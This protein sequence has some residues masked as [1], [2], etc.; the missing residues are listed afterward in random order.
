MSNA[1]ITARLDVITS[2]FLDKLKSELKITNKDVFMMGIRTIVQDKNIQKKFKDDFDEILNNNKYRKDTTKQKNKYYRFHLP[3]NTLR[4][5][6]D[7]AYSSY[8][9]TGYINMK[10]TET[11]INDAIELYNKFSEDEKILL[12]VEMASLDLFKDE[13]YLFSFLRA[14]ARKKGENLLV[15]QDVKRKIDSKRPIRK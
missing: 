8:M 5:I 3:K 9:L 7:Y 10:I 14:E 11:I 6:M 12:K 15:F 13:K 2:N 4:R 1:I